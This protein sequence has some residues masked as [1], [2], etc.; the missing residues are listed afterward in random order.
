VSL[1]LAEVRV[2]E[3]CG[4]STFVKRFLFVM[5]FSQLGCALIAGR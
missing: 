4:I 2:A 5:E 1:A 3:E